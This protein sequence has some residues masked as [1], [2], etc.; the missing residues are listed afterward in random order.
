MLDQKIL[1]T[2]F[3]PREVGGKK[4]NYISWDEY[5]MGITL[6][7]RL[8]SKDPMTQTGACIVDT[9]NRIV[10]IG[11]NGAPIGLKDED[12]PWK[13]REGDYA[14]TKYPYI[15]HGELNAIVAANPK[16]L[17]GC[18]IYTTVFPC[19]ECAKLIIQSGIK[20]IYYLSDK[21]SDSDMNKAAKYMIDKVG[22]KCTKLNMLDKKIVLDFTEENI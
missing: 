20:E 14:D 21:H 10:S 15:C 5:F 8:R 16:D 22:I 2:K 1:Q 11:Y 7:S 4:E 13:V 6:L 19:N 17:H 12:M 3:K 18:K 9:N